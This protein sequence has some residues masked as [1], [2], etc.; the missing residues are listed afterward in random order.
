MAPARDVPT[1]RL[2]RGSDQGKWHAINPTLPSG[3]LPGSRRGRM[4]WPMISAESEAGHQCRAALGMHIRSTADAPI[5]VGHPFIGIPGKS[6]SLHLR[7][8]GWRAPT[9]SDPLAR[10]QEIG[11][12]QTRQTA[13]DNPTSIRM[14]L[15]GTCMHACISAGMHAC[16]AAHQC[17]PPS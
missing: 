3:R 4:P 16:R 9:C 15:H 1:W 5:S 17:Q 6:R 11:S 8:Q 2:R 10:R 12:A 13:A 14:S 7:N